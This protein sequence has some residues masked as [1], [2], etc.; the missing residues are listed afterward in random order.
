MYPTYRVEHFELLLD[1]VTD[2]S[3]LA[4]T[5]HALTE[6]SNLLRQCADP[7]KTEIM[8]ALADLIGRCDELAPKARSVSALPE[9]LRLGLTDAAFA[10][11]RPDEFRVISADIDLIVALQNRNVEVVN[12]Q[13][14]L[15]D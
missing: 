14:L 7:M 12:V 3:A 4:T 8:V 6:A 10:T 2:A 9:F 13:H 5:T 11:L 1:V 15:F